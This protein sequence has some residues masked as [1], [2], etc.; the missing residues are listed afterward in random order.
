MN[1]LK[2]KG[3]LDAAT[4]FPCGLSVSVKNRIQVV[5]GSKMYYNSFLQ[6]SSLTK[7]IETFATNRVFSRCDSFI[8]DKNISLKVFIESKIPNLF[9]KG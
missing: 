9:F 8:L 3:Q 6:T 7:K 2:T 4:L 5:H 1:E